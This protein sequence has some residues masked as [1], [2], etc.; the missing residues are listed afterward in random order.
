MSASHTGK[1]TALD[2]FLGK[3]NSA[4]KVLKAIILGFDRGDYAAAMTD[5][6]SDIEKISSLAGDAMELAAPRRERSRRVNTK[7]WSSI[8]QYA[9]SLFQ[10]IRWQCVCAADH[11]VN[12]RLQIRE[13][14]NQDADAAYLF[15]VLFAYSGK[16]GLNTPLPWIWRKAQV[17]PSEIPQAQ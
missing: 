17:R 12:L 16:L 7:F 13:R 14:S 8:R 10:S 15:V 11:T 6:R 9:E 1:T 3:A 4:R 5:I 2:K